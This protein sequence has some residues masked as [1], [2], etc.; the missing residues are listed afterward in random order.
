MGVSG[1]DQ[2]PRIVWRLPNL[3]L[4]RRLRRTW[5]CTWTFFIEDFASNT[6]LLS[7]FSRVTRVGQPRNNFDS[8]RSQSFKLVWI[9]TK[10]FDSIHPTHP[11][12]RLQSGNHPIWNPTSGTRFALRQVERKGSKKQLQRGILYVLS[13]LFASNQIFIVFGKCGQVSS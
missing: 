13:K 5:S 3:G 2:S 7:P 9:E 11:I 6:R 4:R 1:H 10:N 12:S 8:K